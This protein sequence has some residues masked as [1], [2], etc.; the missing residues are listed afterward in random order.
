VKPYTMRRWRRKSG[1]WPIKSKK[2]IN[3]TAVAACAVG[4]DIGSNSANFTP[5][6]CI[7]VVEDNPAVAERNVEILKILEHSVHLAGF[8]SKA[9]AA[10]FHKDCDLTIADNRR[11]GLSESV[12][13]QQ[14]IEVAP[15]LRI[16]FATGCV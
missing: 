16:I 2:V 4:K 5:P 13:A 3:L 8:G 7:L 14:A 10:L 15:E 12:L 11:P 9:M 1:S 6:Q